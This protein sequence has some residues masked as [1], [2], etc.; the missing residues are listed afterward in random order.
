MLATIT[1]TG[2]DATDLG[3][4][5]HKHPGR[6]QS[7]DLAVGRAHVF[8]PEQ[9]DETCTAA[10]MLEVDAID[11]VRSKRFSGGDSSELGH[12]VNDRPYASSSMLAVA[13]AQVFRT[14]MTGRCDARPELAASP[15]PLTITLAAV[16]SRGEPGLASRL[17]E[18]LGWTVVDA[19][20]PLDP[21]FPE[22]GDSRYS[23]LTLTGTLRLADAL[24]Q[25][26][27]MLPV[28]DDSKHYWVGDDEIGKLLRAGEGW[29]P[30]HPERELITRRYLA[31]QRGLVRDATA[32]LE[33]LD[34]SPVREGLDDAEIATPLRVHRAEAVLTALRDVGAHRVADVGCGPGALLTHLLADSAFTDII[35]T[36]VSHRALDVAERRLHIRDLSD[37]QRDRIRLL[38]SSVTYQDDRLAHLD[39]IVLMEVVEHIE[40][41]R[42]D[43][44]ESSIFGSAAPGAVIVTTPNS[45]YNALYPSLP[46]GRFRHPDHRFEWSRA[47][48]AAWADRVAASHG[49]S[50]EYRPVGDA[51]ETHGSPTQL[52]L[53]RK[54]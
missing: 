4:L 26:Y 28:L 37:R 33:V 23:D 16:P 43:A 27:V 19:A 3:F 20:V 25:L 45:D 14:A 29:L 51:D 35:G 6:L 40:L 1:Y 50:V 21:E 54:A 9:T 47:E 42:L 32:Q 36:D 41:E 38:Q 52:A 13:L 53:F 12:Y 5:L 46:A 11:L 34:G 2:P 24:H 30:A 18:P 48:F 22:W 7:F 15:L 44:L 17:F 31:H 10:L 8:Y 49:Y 39:A